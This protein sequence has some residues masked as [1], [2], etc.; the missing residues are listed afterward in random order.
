MET[1]SW[2]LTQHWK[3][4]HTVIARG[5]RQRDIFWVAPVLLYHAWRLRRSADVFHLGDGVLAPLAPCI[6]ALTRKPVVITVHGLEVTYAHA[7]PFYPHL[8]AWGLRATTHIVCVSQF[9]AFLLRERGI[10]ESRITVIPHGVVAPETMQ[11]ALARQTV[12]SRAEMSPTALDHHYVLLTVGRLVKRKGVA[13][14]IENVLPRIRDL[15]PLYIVTS[16]GPDAEHIRRIVQSKELD[17]VVKLVGK[18]SPETLA[19]L[20]AGADVFVMPNIS[21]PHDVEGFGFVPVE[22]AA[23]GLPVV[24]SRLEGIPDAIHDQK[25]GM[26]YTPNDP[27]ACAALLRTWHEH[28]AVRTAFGEQ[29]RAY[30][31]EHFRWEDVVQQYAVVFSN[32][33]A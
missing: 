12:A 22:A 20:Y 1:F 10:A 17:A 32:A 7:G 9:T 33:H 6:R 19:H 15:K 8:I 27:A 2:Q 18:V 23:H 16:T 13:W 28:P 26:L 14:F 31:R 5:K 4:D 3:G 25:N 21:V 24:A 29:A 30:T 11:R